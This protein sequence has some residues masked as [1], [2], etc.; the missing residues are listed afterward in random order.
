[1]T[2]SSGNISDMSANVD[3]SNSAGYWRI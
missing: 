1:M 2:A 3:K